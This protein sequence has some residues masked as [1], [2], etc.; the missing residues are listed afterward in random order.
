MT[1][2]NT[3]ESQQ[4]TTEEPSGDE[5]NSDDSATGQQATEETQPSQDGVKPAQE[6]DEES[7]RLLAEVMKQKKRAQIAEEELRVNK[8]AQMTEEEQQAAKNAEILAENKMYKA[9]ARKGIL[10]DAVTGMNGKD[11]I[12]LSAEGVRTAIDL[13]DSDKVEW[14]ESNNPLNLTSLVLEVQQKH[15]VVTSTTVAPGSNL[16]TGS[17]QSQRPLTLSQ[18][19][20]ERANESGMGVDKY[21][22]W[23][24]VITAADAEKLIRSQN[25]AS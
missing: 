14:D 1:D 24:K 25:G 9:Q 19:Q 18:A 23:S 15:P 2:E 17:G 5:T 16:N 22:D 13:I 11:G 6:S 21:A 8:L 20:L 7:P 4:V 12:K 10:Q 3:Q